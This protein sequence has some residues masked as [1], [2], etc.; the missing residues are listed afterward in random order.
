MDRPS[1]KLSATGGVTAV[2]LASSGTEAT[3]LPAVGMLGTSLRRGAQ[4][5]LA[6]PG[7]LAAYRAR[8]ATGLPLLAPWANRLGGWRYTVAGVDVDLKGLD[9]P[10]D[11]KRL[12]IHGTMLA[13]PRWE[14]VR[15][16]ANGRS[17][18]LVARF[19]QA[20]LQDQLRAFPF[21]HEL[22]FEATVD[23]AGSVSISLRLRPTG[24]RSVPVS[25][26]FHP[27]FRLP[28]GRRSQWMLRLP[29]RRHI[30]L[31][32][33]GIPTNGSVQEPEEG[34]PIGRRTFDDLYELGPDRSVELRHGSAAIS[35]SLDEK[36]PFLQ[37]FAPPGRGFVC[38]EPMT[39]PVDAL[40]SGRCPLVRPGD[41]FEARFSVSIGSPAQRKEPPP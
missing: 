38:L 6:L 9:L 15:I 11:G 12:P 3:F 18:S 24:E 33:R 2:H 1:V 26:G 27:Y 32:H 10:T 29:A 41:E 13:D 30:E 31:D 21:S 25:F 22:T 20:G 14:I 5:F 19:D 8:R 23:A 34:D 36:Y 16:A 39:A 28:T 40:R 7:G 35:L 17:A 4:E 37:V